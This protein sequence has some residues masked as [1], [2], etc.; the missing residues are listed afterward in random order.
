MKESRAEK[1]KRYRLKHGDK[2]RAKAKLRYRE[3]KEYKDNIRKASAK[4]YRKNAKHVK[5]R[6]NEPKNRVRINS[7]RRQRIERNKEWVLNYKHSHPCIKC[8]ENDPI[9]LQFHHL[10]DKKFNISR[11]KG[12]SC[13]LQKIQDEVTKCVILCA[14]CH[15]REHAKKK[16]IPNSIQ[17]VEI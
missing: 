6:D 3:N 15:L 7:F 8:G 10:Q 1:S 2:I 16:S 11:K 12:E 5:D 17:M 4:W 9:V 14:N 13:S